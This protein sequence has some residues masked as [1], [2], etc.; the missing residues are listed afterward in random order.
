MDDRPWSPAEIE[1]KMQAGVELRN[2]AV[3]VFK[4]LGE[5]AARKQN[6]YDTEYAKMIL[7]ARTRS[8]LT[9]DVLRKAWAVVQTSDLK[10]EA[11]IAAVL[12]AAQ[13]ETIK[14]LADDGD[15][16]RTMLVSARGVQ[17]PRR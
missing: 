13:R 16:Y 7:L 3:A 12:F 8:E 17:D 11:D 6:A 1:E 2:D 9:S 10:L 5:N 4:A 14:E 15:Q